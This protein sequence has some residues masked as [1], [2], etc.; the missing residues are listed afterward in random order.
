MPAFVSPTGP[1]V[2]TEKNPKNSWGMLGKAQALK[3]VLQQ[4]WA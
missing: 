4:G 2:K 3:K 1:T